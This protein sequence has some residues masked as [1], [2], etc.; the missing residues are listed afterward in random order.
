MPPRNDRRRRVLS[1]ELLNSASTEV[2]SPAKTVPAGDALR[3]AQGAQRQSQPRLCD[4]VP[5]RPL[6]VLLTLGAGL[7]L[8]AGVLVPTLFVDELAQ[9]VPRASLAAFEP[10]AAHGMVAWLTTLFLL[11]NFNAALLVYSLRRHR[12]DDYYGRYRVWLAVAAASLLASVAV[13]TG[14]GSLAAAVLAPVAQS[15]HLSGEYGL[16]IVLALAGAYL[17]VRLTMEL[18]RARLAFVTFLL[19]VSC[20]ATAAS[21]VLSWEGLLSAGGRLLLGSTLKLLGCLFIPMTT[22]IFARHV[23]LDI[24]GKIPQRVAEPRRKAKV[25]TKAPR[26]E[27]TTDLPTVAASKTDDSTRRVDPPQKLKPIVSPRSDLATGS[28]GSGRAAL[29]SRSSKPATAASEADDEGDQAANDRDLSQLT[30][31]ER[32]RLKRDAKLA[33]RAEAA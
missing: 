21:G 12:V 4:L 27:R 9:H 3:Y 26:T 16:P 7:I 28:A 31:A 8:V 13:S 5:Q 30:R 6:S 1:D 19:A 10:N 32:K 29:L 14:A 17:A 33:R 24:E 22:L 18:Y 20:L 25:K 11:V 23:L 15:C 2:A